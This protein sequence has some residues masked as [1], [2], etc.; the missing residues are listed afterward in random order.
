MKQGRMVKEKPWISGAVCVKDRDYP[1][2]RYLL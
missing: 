2:L 1:H